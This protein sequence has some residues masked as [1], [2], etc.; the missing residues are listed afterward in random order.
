MHTRLGNVHR[1]S[2]LKD[3]VVA[4][5]EQDLLKD[6]KVISTGNVAVSCTLNYLK[7]NASRFSLLKAVFVLY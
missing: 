4:A 3:N 5:K 7:R 1:L 2:V 6:E